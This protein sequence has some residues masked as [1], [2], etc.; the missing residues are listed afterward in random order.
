MNEILKRQELKDRILHEM[1]IL[2]FLDMLEI[3]YEEII[4]VLLENA[5]EEQRETIEQHFLAS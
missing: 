4:D 3:P 5:T 2:Q 1:D